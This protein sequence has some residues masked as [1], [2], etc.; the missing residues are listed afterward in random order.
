MTDRGR[1]RRG[2][3]AGLIATRLAAWRR[4]HGDAAI[5]TRFA[6]APT[7]YLHLGHVAN[8]VYVWG[9]AAVV[10]ALV[11]LRIEDHDRGRCRPE[12][13]TALLVD[14]EWLGLEPGEPPIKT[15]RTGTP[16]AYRQSDSGAAYEEAL[17]RLAAAGL[18][19]GCDCARSTFDAWAATT[20]EPFHGP[21][22]PGDCRVRGLKMRQGLSVR[23]A[24]GAGEEAFVDL[25][26]GARSGDPSAGGDLLA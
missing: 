1:S 5:R 6:P 25:A 4:D 9:V 2:G 21:G 26:L 19:Y 15:L 10:G 20:G 22:C 8:A 17:G 12:Y 7:G 18:V 23:V 11:V 3:Q 24:I 16:S 14:L 13:E